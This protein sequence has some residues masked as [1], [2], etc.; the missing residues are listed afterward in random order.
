MVKRII[1]LFFICIFAFGIFI[2]IYNA[3]ENYDSYFVAN[4]IKEQLC[5]TEYKEMYVKAR[6]V[7]AFDI[8]NAFLH[9]VSLSL[10]SV[11]LFKTKPQKL[12]KD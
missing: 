6:N 5:E 12:E 7:F 11:I 3:V 9:F 1:L 10:C 2:S 4:S 8:I